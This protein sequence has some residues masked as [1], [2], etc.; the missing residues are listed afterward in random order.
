MEQTINRGAAV[1]NEPAWRG[2]LSLR[3]PAGAV[4]AAGP[5]ATRSGHPSS[6]RCELL[7]GAQVG[8]PTPLGR[9]K[10]AAHSTALHLRHLRRRFEI[11]R[12]RSR[13][14]GVHGAA[15][16]FIDRGNVI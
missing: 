12:I 2:L 9:E 16:Q 15:L 4:H 3:D 8:K 7:H 1:N 10:A 14:L 11:E 5:P 6:T 13:A